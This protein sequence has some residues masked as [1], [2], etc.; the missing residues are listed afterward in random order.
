MAALVIDDY[1]ED[2]S[3]LA[4]V[5]INGRAEILL[6]G[7]NEHHRAVELLREKYEQYRSMAID[8]A[9][10]IRLVPTAIKHWRS[11]PKVKQ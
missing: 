3:E 6:P 10:V 2:W 9:P 1:S 7:N 11:S 4:W 8:K 5:L